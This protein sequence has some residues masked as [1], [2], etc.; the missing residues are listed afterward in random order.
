[1]T[2]L[3]VEMNECDHPSQQDLDEYVFGRLPEFQIEAMEIHVLTCE[4]CVDRLENLELHIATIKLAL[5]SLHAEQTA[6]ILEPQTGSWNWLPMPQVSWI[7]IAALITMCVSPLHIAWRSRPASE[8]RLHA[9]RGSDVDFV[10]QGRSLL[11]HV[12][13]VDLPEEVISVQVVDGDG[14]EVW[15]GRTVIRNDEGRILLPGFSKSGSYFLRLYASRAEDDSPSLLR[16]FGFRV[17]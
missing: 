17:Q 6:E 11:L 16:E 5:G 2:A 14:D 1:M 8:V 13:T 10:P 3:N 9:Y 15:T 4:S 7:L 12:N